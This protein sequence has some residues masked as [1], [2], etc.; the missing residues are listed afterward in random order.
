MGLLSAE[1]ERRYG[2]DYRVQYDTGSPSALE[3]LTAL[4]HEGVP[5]ALVL[6]DQWMPDLIARGPYGFVITGPDL[7]GESTVRWPLDRDSMRFETSLP[8][9]FAVGDI[10]PRSVMRVA[11]AVGEGSVVIQDVY[12]LVTDG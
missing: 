10:R 11:A 4:R 8:G 7:Q 12:R 1:L 3:R 9:V 2:R 6:A 5:V